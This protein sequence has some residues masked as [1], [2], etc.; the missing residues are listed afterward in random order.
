MTNAFLR[1]LIGLSILICFLIQMPVSLWAKSKKSPESAPIELNPEY[2]LPKND[3]EFR[4]RSDVSEK[5]VFKKLP[6]DL[7]MDMKYSFWGYGSLAFGLGAGMSGAFVP[8]DDNIQNSFDQGALFG[9][10]GDDIIGWTLSPYTLFG[11]SFITFLVAHNTGH[12]KLAT[13]TLAISEAIFLSTAVTFAGKLAFRRERP[14]GGNFSFPSEHA[15]AAFATAGVLT[16]MYGWKAGVPSFALASLVSISRVDADKH[17]VSDVLMGA[18]IGTVIGVGTA[19]F[20]MKE[21]PKFFI[22]GSA[23][24]DR[25]TVGVTFLH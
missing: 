4:Q 7:G 25:A 5:W 9:D 23:A 13:T 17:W 15:S 21:N 1:R 24:H 8:I 20:H 11:T 3:Q 14:D 10:T 18:V 12:P 2:D 16:T 19:K 6:R 22:T